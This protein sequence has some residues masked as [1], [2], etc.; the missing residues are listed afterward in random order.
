MSKKKQ[1]QIHAS[2]DVEPMVVEPPPVKADA[3]DP[4]DPPD[5]PPN[6]P[7]DDPSEPG[8]KPVN[9]YQRFCAAKRAE[10]M[11][12]LMEQSPELYEDG[13][14]P[15]IADIS[16]ELGKRWGDLGD[17]EKGPF[18]SAYNEEN[19][20]YKKACDAYYTRYPDRRP[21]KPNRKRPAKASSS[22][23]SKK[24]KAASSSNR[25]VPLK[26]GKQ[27]YFA[28][29]RE[30]VRAELASAQGGGDI[31]KSIVMEH[32]LKA[33]RRWSRVKKRCGLTRRRS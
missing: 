15:K 18:Q 2:S 4:P 33:W 17:A 12:V 6:P 29:S 20:A 23:E 32:M 11:R 19:K 8:K 13:R 31:S 28:A 10:V 27:L 7:D 26:N 1:K 9:P 30:R 14:K 21:P 3:A 24:K 16:K 5:P 22:S 25:R